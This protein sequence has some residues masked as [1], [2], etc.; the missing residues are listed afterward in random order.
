M[1]VTHRIIFLYLSDRVKR[2]RD[3]FNINPRVLKSLGGSRLGCYK[4]GEVKV[5]IPSNFSQ[6]VSACLSQPPQTMLLH[7]LLRRKLR[8]WF[9]GKLRK[10][11][12]TSQAEVAFTADYV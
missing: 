4:I 10:E 3:F 11:S 8:G 12:A 6:V 5:E 9:V 1:N 2:L 7:M